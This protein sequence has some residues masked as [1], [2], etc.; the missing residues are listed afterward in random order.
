MLNKI[1]SSSVV[2][3]FA[4]LAGCRASNTSNTL[5]TATSVKNIKIIV[6][7]LDFKELNSDGSSSSQVCWAVFAGAE[8]FPSDES[9]VT[10]K[11]CFPVIKSAMIFEIKDLPATTNGYVVSLFQDTNKNNKLDT[12]SFLGLK[13]PNEPFGFSNNPNLMGAPTYEKCKI[14]PQKEGEEFT[15]QMKRM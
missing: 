8:G 4:L 13:I 11:G 3:V 5:D 14:V 6:R 9:K 7:G 1:F 15:I 2:V 12:R 10:R